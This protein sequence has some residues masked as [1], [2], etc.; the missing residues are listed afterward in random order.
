MA[1]IRLETGEWKDNSWV[2]FEKPVEV[3][4][5]RCL[6]L[7]VFQED[8][9]AMSDVY[10]VATFATV[11]DLNE[12]R[13]KRVLVNANFECDT[14]QGRAV[15]DAAP[16]IQTLHTIWKQEQAKIAEQHRAAQHAAAAAA[17]RQKPVVGKKMTVVKGRTAK[18][19]TG[20][21]CVKY[22]TDFGPK[23]LM[24]ARLEDARNKNIPGHWVYGYN[25]KLAE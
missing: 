24:K 25:L 6:V 15:V 19:Y 18:G 13:P 12:K 21:C 22:D 1:I 7:S 8:Y 14:S 11:W 5:H 10:T 2:K 16:P 3:V 23:F 9:R 17:E 20:Y 4:T